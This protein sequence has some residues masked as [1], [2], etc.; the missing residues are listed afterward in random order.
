MIIRDLDSDKDWKFGQGKNNYLSDDNAIVLNI[1]TRLREWY[2][3]CFF[4]YINGIDWYN[5]LN[6]NQKAALDLDVRNIIL[7]S[8]GVMQLMSFSGSLIGRQYKAQYNIKTIFS[9]SLQGEVAV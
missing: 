5:R 9:Q 1:E 2:G 3:D 8:Y 4:A 6:K 7:G